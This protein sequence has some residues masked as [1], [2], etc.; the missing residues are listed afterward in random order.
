MDAE[1]RDEFGRNSRLLA[2]KEFSIDKVIDLT[3]NIYNKYLES[4]W[5]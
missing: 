1:K 3:F 2:E 4:N 5:P